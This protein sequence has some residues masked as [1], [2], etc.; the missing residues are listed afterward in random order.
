MDEPLKGLNI[1]TVS[2]E[3]KDRYYEMASKDKTKEF[4]AG[5]WRAD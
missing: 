5:L 4:F 1:K 2:R 3:M